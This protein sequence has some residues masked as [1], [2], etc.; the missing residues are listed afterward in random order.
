MDSNND[1]FITSQDIIS[2]SE[3][4]YLFLDP[5]VQHNIYKVSSQN[6]NRCYEC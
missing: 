3:K 1:G 2:F 4:H 6:G 5:D